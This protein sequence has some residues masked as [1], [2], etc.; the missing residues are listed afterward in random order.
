[1]AAAPSYAEVLKKDTD[2]D[3]KEHDSSETEANSTLHNTSS[4]SYEPSASKGI[5]TISSGG[6]DDN[7]TSRGG[8]DKK[9]KKLSKKTI[10]LSAT[11]DIALAGMLIGWIYKKPTATKIQIDVHEDTYRVSNDNDKYIATL[12][13]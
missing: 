10:I 13:P 1:M 3:N 11:L 12:K 6:V 2:I 8:S 4:Y 9:S 5:I 7:Y